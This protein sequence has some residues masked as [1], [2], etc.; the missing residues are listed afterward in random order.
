MSTELIKIENSAPSL[1]KVE[2]IEEGRG[3]L[4][5][6]YSIRRT[7]NGVVNVI[8]KKDKE[9]R[10]VQ[11]ELRDLF[12]S[13]RVNF[14]KECGYY[15]PNENVYKILEKD[16]TVTS[17][18]VNDNGQIQLSGVR[19]V[20]GGEAEISIKGPVMSESDYEEEDYQKVVETIESIKLE[21]ESFMKGIKGADAKIIVM[22]YLKVKRGLNDT[23]GAYNEMSDEEIDAI[24]KD[25]LEEMGLDILMEDGRSV[26][27]PSEVHTPVIRQ[28]LVIPK[29]TVI[30]IDH[31][32]FEEDVAPIETIEDSDIFPDFKDEE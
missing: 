25:A 15:W 26:I 12:N 2:L 13:L 3:G 31:T 4:Q 22:D 1:Q 8:D 23:E 14:L 17:V 7:R 21:S 24:M 20:K 27:A 9:H 16:T 32:P 5:V 19:R 10:P 28:E 29:K 18:S 30:E 6:T 11:K